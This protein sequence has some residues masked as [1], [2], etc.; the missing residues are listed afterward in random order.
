VAKPAP[1][2]E[3][4]HAL[5][6]DPRLKL[7][8]RYAA[9]VLSAYWDGDGRKAFPSITTLTEKTGMSRRTVIRALVGI[10][11]LGIVEAEKRRG[12][13]TTYHAVIPYPTS[14]TRASPQLST[15]GAP[16]T[17]TSAAGAPPL[18]PPEHQEVVRKLTQEG[19]SEAPLEE[20]D[21]QKDQKTGFQRCW[22]DGCIALRGAGSRYCE[23][24]RLRRE[25][26][27]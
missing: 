18:V 27:A 26:A 25:Q 11:A 24:H 15:P 23:Q 12:R 19:A 7:R 20:D 5:L 22:A 1:L 6:D 4:R 3:W 13:T 17:P 9:L 14:A 16:V 2:I 21:L 8:E 10:N